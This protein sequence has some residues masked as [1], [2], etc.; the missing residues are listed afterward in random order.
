M[1]DERQVSIDER[2]LEVLVGATEAWKAWAALPGLREQPGVEMAL[3]QVEAA[4]NAARRALRG[5]DSGDLPR[6]SWGLRSE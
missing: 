5:T 4:L 1:L 6:L 3:F 2:A